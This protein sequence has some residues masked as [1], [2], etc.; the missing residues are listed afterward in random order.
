MSD[1]R[2]VQERRPATLGDDGVSWLEKA[3]NDR[4]AAINLIGWAG[5]QLTAG[6]ILP[7]TVSR[8]IGEAL[9]AVAE[10]RHTNGFNEV[11]VIFFI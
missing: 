11:F 2:E 8:A 3:R 7:P 4:D 1:N 9:I 5:E 6:N 10:A